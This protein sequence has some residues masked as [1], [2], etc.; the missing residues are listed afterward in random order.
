MLDYVQ[1]CKQQLTLLLRHFQASFSSPSFFSL[2]IWNFHQSV[3][4]TL[5]INTV[6]WISLFENQMASSPA[7]G[8]RENNL[9]STISFGFHFSF[10][11]FKHGIPLLP[12]VVHALR[13]QCVYSMQQASSTSLPP[14]TISHFP[15]H[16]PLVPDPTAHKRENKIQFKTVMG[17]IL[18]LFQN[19]CLKKKALGQSQEKN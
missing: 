12:V 9:L 4:Y 15:P 3:W 14:R 17:I 7:P 6:I 11:V 10:L 13:R 1:E 19:F 18:E 2:S 16:S 5:R 8:K